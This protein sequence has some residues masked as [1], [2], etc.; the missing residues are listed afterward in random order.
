MSSLLRY[1][2]EDKLNLWQYILYGLENLLVMD[3]VFAT[4]VVLGI[5][6]HMQFTTLIYFIQITLIGA[7]ITTILQSRVLLR[8]PVAQ[9][10]AASMTGV[11]I[12]LS[13]FNL[14]LSTIITGIIISTLSVGI[15]LIPFIPSNKN[16]I[17]IKKSIFEY[18]LVLVKAPQVYGSLITI[19]GVILINAAVGLLNK[20]NYTVMS[21]IGA[22][23]T[24]IAIIALIVLFNKGILRYASIFIGFLIGVI[25]SMITGMFSFSQV[26]KYPLFSI[27]TLFF[28]IKSYGPVTTEGLELVILPAFIVTVILMGE[29]VGA[30]YTVAGLDTITLEDK[31]VR[32]GLVGEWLGTL[33]SLIFGGL[34]TSTFA[35]NIGSIQI[36]KVGARRVF[37]WT[38]IFLIIFGFIPK[39]GAFILSVPPA[40]LGATFI[41]IYMMLF[42]TGLRIISTIKWTD[43][44]VIV[45]G[46][47]LLFGLIISQIPVTVF[48]SIPIYI[49]SALISSVVLTAGTAVILNL[50][51]NLIPEWVKKPKLTP[52]SSSNTN[53]T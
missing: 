24:F 51:L 38:G 42:I 31:R 36:T 17:K 52:K 20:G 53:S 2:F 19:L 34:T 6:L 40:V 46:V 7:G 30:Y 14:D 26:I 8:L 25:Y 47:S 41:I 13:V 44:N 18:L 9:G 39:I 37:T 29:A 21:N 4:P 1:H 43:A 27:P 35:Q 45:V 23:I 22:T 3:S 33:I 28:T 11:V 48:A 50:L 10:I 15:L 12:T 49:R 5:A 32:N 16:G